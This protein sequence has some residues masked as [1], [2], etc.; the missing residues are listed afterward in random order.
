MGL[1]RHMLYAQLSLNLFTKA[2][3]STA[4]YNHMFIR[5]KSINFLLAYHYMYL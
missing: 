1:K 4:V 5:D 2:L 3:K